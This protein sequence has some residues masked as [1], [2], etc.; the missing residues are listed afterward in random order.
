MQQKFLNEA[1]LKVLIEQIESLISGKADTTTVES[2]SSRLATLESKP[3]TLKGTSAE[4]AL[5]KEVYPAGTIIVVTDG[6]SVNDG[7]TTTVKPTF[8]IADGKSTVSQLSF[9]SED[10]LNQSDKNIVLK[11]KL[12]IG[13]IE[14]DGSTDVTVPVYGSEFE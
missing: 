1:G 8:K 3:Q 2:I 13:T 5:D 4:W 9:V 12:T 7:T 10:I 11:N 14:Y 6:M